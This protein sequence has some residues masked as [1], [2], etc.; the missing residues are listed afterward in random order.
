MAKQQTISLPALASNRTAAIA[1]AE[2]ELTEQARADCHEND[3]V[4][5]ISS[6]VLVELPYGSTPQQ[7]APIIGTD[8]PFG[9][10]YL[11]IDAPDMSVRGT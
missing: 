1:V 11:S 6:S 2:L 8:E 4:V 7:A 3:A 10:T 5:A 9:S